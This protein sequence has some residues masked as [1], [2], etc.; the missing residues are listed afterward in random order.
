MQQSNNVCLP[1]KKQAP[2]KKLPAEEFVERRSPRNLP[3]SNVR[4]RSPRLNPIQIP[5]PNG[6]DDGISGLSPIDEE[7]E[8][9]PENGSSWGHIQVHEETVTAAVEAA[10]GAGQE[11]VPKLMGVN[12]SESLQMEKRNVSGARLR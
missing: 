8:A 9:M 4:R 10:D 12:V 11:N 7:T 3:T 5:E 6:N 1:C 2:K